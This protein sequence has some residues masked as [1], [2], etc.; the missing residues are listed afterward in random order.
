MHIVIVKN[1]L[2]CAGKIKD[3]RACL[4]SLKRSGLSLGGFLLKKE[5]AP[6]LESRKSRL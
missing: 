5:P 2:L 4:Q 6:T 1:R 3:L